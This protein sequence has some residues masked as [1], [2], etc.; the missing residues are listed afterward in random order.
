MQHSV[1][2]N[3]LSYFIY[4]GVYNIKKQCET[5]RVWITDTLYTIKSE[6]NCFVVGVF[7]PVSLQFVLPLK[8]FVTWKLLF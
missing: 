4:K 1:L 2:Y 7:P 3:T 6:A 5:P 8:L